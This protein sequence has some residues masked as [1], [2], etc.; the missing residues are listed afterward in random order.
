[1]RVGLGGRGGW[2]DGFRD[3][4]VVGR[5]GL[6][7]GRCFGEG[8]GDG[9]GVCL[10]PS[11][12]NSM[13]HPNFDAHIRQTNFNILMCKEWFCEMRNTRDIQDALRMPHT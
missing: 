1:M 7:I 11:L 4:E 12:Q 9:D 5:M 13:G 3:G 8:V 2:E 10:H 6:G